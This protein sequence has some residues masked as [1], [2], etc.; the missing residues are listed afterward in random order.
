MK[1]TVMLY[2]TPVVNGEELV[3]LKERTRHSH[4]FDATIE[5]SKRYYFLRTRYLDNKKERKNTSPTWP[6]QQ[7]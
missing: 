1:I 4:V 2:V 5:I 7:W 3:R 6:K